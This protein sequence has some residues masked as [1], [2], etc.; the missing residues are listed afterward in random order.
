MKPLVHLALLVLIVATCLIYD[1]VSA[2]SE[3]EKRDAVPNS[4]TF[5]L[6]KMFCTTGILGTG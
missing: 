6:G 5:H 1:A 3:M 2:S 4:C